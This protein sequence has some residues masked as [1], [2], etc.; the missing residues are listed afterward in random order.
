MPPTGTS[1]TM[2]ADR[3]TPH[4]LLTL[5]KITTGLVLNCALQLSPGLSFS[6]GSTMSGLRAR[7][8]L[9]ATLISSIALSGGAHAEEEQDKGPE[10]SADVAVGIEYDS[11]I[12]VEEVDVAISESDYALT[13][14]LGVGLKQ[15]LTEKTDL[16]LSYD[17]SQSN[18]NE[19]SQVDRQ[20]HMLG[21]DINL[22]LEKVD[23]NLS[24]Y[25]I[26]ARLDGEEF[27]EL[28]RFSPSVSG[29]L[30]KKWYARAAYVYSEKTIA[31]NPG[32]DAD[33][34]AGE[35]DFYYFRRGLRSY[36]NFGYRFKDEDAVADRL[37]YGS[38][39]LKLRYIQRIEAF[40]RTTKLEL[41]WR[42]EDRDYSSITPGI[43]E[44]R[45]DERHRWR[46][47]YEIP[48]WEGGA[49]QLYYSY[50]D[51]DSNYEPVDY[52]QTIAGTRFIYRW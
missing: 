26:H 11:N 42:Y 33:T 22:D 23:T 15:P 14:D 47:D 2:A 36:F 50:G 32:R 39:G 13:L 40:T 46:V 12:S 29:F 41:A 35:A 3:A 28:Y 8:R 49:I 34:N 17:F 27:L 9:I 24:L 31:D 37:D 20:T 1:G 43:G 51:Y 7:R 19:F 30:S 52:N 5:T 48:V 4:P 18:Y 6:P 10:W 21:S 38:H 16:G 44:K 45:H 25:Y